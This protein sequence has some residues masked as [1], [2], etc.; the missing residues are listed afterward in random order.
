MAGILKILARNH[1]IAKAVF[2]HVLIH[3][4]DFSKAKL[5]DCIFGNVTRFHSTNFTGAILESCKFNGRFSDCDFRY[6]SWDWIKASHT[7]FENCLFINVSFKGCALRRATF[8]GCT[9]LNCSFI[10]CDLSQVHFSYSSNIVSCAFI[11][12]DFAQIRLPDLFIPT[13]INESEN[14][15]YIPMVCPDEGEFIGY[16]KAWTIDN[17][18]RYLVL[19]T[20]RIPADAIRSSGFGRKCRCS[21]AIVEKMEWISPEVHPLPVPMARSVWDERFIYTEGKEVEPRNG[22]CEDRWAV[23]S[24]GIHFFMNKQEAIDY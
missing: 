6:S 20:L 17:G 24:A 21:K 8:K 1:S 4:S 15:P 22:F 11:R 9:F 23:C 12:C 7:L 14:V 13:V 3:D 10:G 16:K 2:D 5:T 18:M 19:I